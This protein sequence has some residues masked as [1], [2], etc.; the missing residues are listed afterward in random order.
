MQK[1]ISIIVPIYNVEQYLDKCI[2]S[3]QCQ[4]YDNLEIILVDDGSPDQCGDICE[5]YAK[6]DDRIR[7]IHKKN[8]GLAD[9]RNHGLE[10]AT[11]DYIA[12][13]DSDDYIHP[14]MYERMMKVAI[15]ENSD[16]VICDWKKVLP[17]ENDSFE[18]LNSDKYQLQ[19]V[20]GKKIQYLYFEE[21]DSRI[22]YTVAWNKL[23]AKEIFQGRRFPTGKVH[24]DEFVT[25]KTLYDAK[26]IV[27]LQEALYFYLMRDASI[28]GKFNVKRFD[29][30]DAYAE[31]I[32]FFSSKGE[33]ELASKTYFMAAHM[34][35]QYS[36][37]VGKRNKDAA[38]VYK[39]YYKVWKKK[40]KEYKDSIICSP[41]Q[42]VEMFIFNQV[43]PL[44]KL[45]WKAKH[46]VKKQ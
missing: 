18:K 2:K 37:W 4:T 32:A 11:G 28:M 43:F 13:V 26:K 3:I 5:R 36:E 20:D 46:F 7:V 8:G 34:L 22:T 30:F 39:K 19:N 6:E 33:K 17:N 31:K 44:Y 40:G 35:V 16:I 10:I 9:A 15:E 21:P 12:F 25:F 45:M 23:Y 38:D 27:Y 14:Q 41:T 42:K 29:I 24:E 1:L